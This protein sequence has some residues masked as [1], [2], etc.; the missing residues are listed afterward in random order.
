[1]KT[2]RVD[3]MSMPVPKRKAKF[4]QFQLLA[5]SKNIIW[6]SGRTTPY[7][8]TRL[9]QFLPGMVT[10]LSG[11]DRRNSWSMFSSNCKDYPVID[12]K[13]ALQLLKEY[14]PYEAREIDQRTVQSIDA[15]TT[16][17]SYTIPT[18]IVGGAIFTSWG[19]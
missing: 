17:T 12:I 16:A 18:S 4:R 3:F 2:F 11:H 8:I 6:G 14:K 1:M 5:F 10:I 19:E 9:K 15:T 7:P 13:E